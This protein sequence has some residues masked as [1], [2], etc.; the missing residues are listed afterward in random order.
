MKEKLFII[1]DYIMAEDIKKM[2]KRLELTQKS[3]RNW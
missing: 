3:L 1:P 2:R